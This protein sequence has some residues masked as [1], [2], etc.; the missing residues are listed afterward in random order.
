MQVLL[1]RTLKN[2]TIFIT[3]G[4]RGIGKAIA[5]RA[6]R[7]GANIIIAAKSD[8]PLP[9]LPGTIYSVA[10]EIEQAGG[11]AL[12]VKLDVRDDEAITTVA[13]QAVDRFGGIDILVNN[14]SAINLTGTLET[15]M[16]RFDLMFSVNVR[17][18][19]ATSQA[20]L[21][22]LLASDNP[23]ILNLS[24]PLNLDPKWFRDHTAYTM[25]KYGMSMCVIG[26]AAEFADD[27]VAVNGLWPRTVIDTAAL[28][29]LGDTVDPAC[30]RRSDIMADAAHYILTR[31]SREY[32]GQLLID[33]DVLRQAG[34]ADFDGY[35]VD[36]S[37]ELATDLFLD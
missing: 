37:R 31:D 18:T 9:N 28:R 32:T 1:M 5:L 7:D 22:A 2:K 19:F 35:A 17:G 20:C 6:A 21:P 3:G 12:P 16:R 34:I 23:H 36:P 29:M 25:S 26:M 33:E 11:Q 10:E 15:P 24:P 4:T 8:K 14:A 30:C 27:G 13:G